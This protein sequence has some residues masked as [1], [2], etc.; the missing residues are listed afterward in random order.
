MGGK[1]RQTFVFHEMRPET[2]QAMRERLGLREWS[3]GEEK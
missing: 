3:V 2:L 1:G